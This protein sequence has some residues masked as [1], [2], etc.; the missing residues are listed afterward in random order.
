L[1]FTQRANFITVL[2]EIVPAFYRGYGSDLTAWKRPA[3]NIKQDRVS[4]DDVSPDAISSDAED[5]EA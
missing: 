2:K 1:P 3:P 4:A 5:F